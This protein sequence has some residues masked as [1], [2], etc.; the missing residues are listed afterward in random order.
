MFLK[1]NHAHFRAF[2]FTSRSFN[3]NYKS[4]HVINEEV[5]FPCDSS[6]WCYIH[7]PNVIISQM[8]FLMLSTSSIK[9]VGSLYDS[10]NS[11][12]SRLSLG[13][14]F[15]HELVILELWTS[16]KVT[17][18]WNKLMHFYP[19]EGDIWAASSL[20]ETVGFE[21]YQPF[22]ILSAFI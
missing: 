14:F 1:R 3:W 4:V 15:T 17:M 19:L 13:T 8:I 10:S 16:F 22:E 11:I 2:P 7:S 6:L 12:T 5:F 21:A 18:P 20:L 9:F